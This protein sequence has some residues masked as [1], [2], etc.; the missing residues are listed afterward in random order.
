VRLAG[1]GSTTSAGRVEVFVNGS[2]GLICDDMFYDT[3][4]AGV[5]Q[6]LGFDGGIMLFVEV[7]G[8]GLAS[9]SSFPYR[10][11]CKSTATNVTE[12]ATIPAQLE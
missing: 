10:M 5:C 11:S 12:C 1:D 3:D 6:A 4:A 8:D 2:W 7:V 9:S